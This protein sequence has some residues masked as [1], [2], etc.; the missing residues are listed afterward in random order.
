MLG[1]ALLCAAFLV[2]APRLLHPFL[3]P[4]Y[5]IRDASG[6]LA[7]ILEP[8]TRVVGEVADELLPG[9]R[10]RTLVILDRERM[11]YGRFGTSV[12]RLDEV[13]PTHVLLDGEVAQA[14][15][16]RSISQ[17]LAGWGRLGDGTVR[18]FRFGDNGEGGHRFVSTLAPVRPAE[19]PK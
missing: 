11:G 1:I 13:R 12:S 16:E 5:S 17:L 15:L 6:A 4:S 18:V 7:A 8:D 9:T 14:D 3:S 10:H 19:I 2:T